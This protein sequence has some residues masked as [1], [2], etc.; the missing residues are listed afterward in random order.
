MFKK[1]KLAPSPTCSCGLEDQTPDN[2]LQN[3]QQLKTLKRLNL[4]NSTN[5]S[6][7]QTLWLQAGPGSRSMISFVSLSGLAVGRVNE[8]KKKKGYGRATIFLIHPS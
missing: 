3:C 2:L 4:A 1:L 7:Y 5:S 8:K 6:V